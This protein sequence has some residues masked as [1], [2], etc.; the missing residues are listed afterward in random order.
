VPHGDWHSLRTS[1][2]CLP[3]A[4]QRYGF[5]DR[6][7]SFF[8]RPAD[9]FET[10]D[11]SIDLRE[12]LDALERLEDADPAES[13]PW[14]WVTSHVFRK[15]RLDSTRLDE[16]AMSPREIADILGHAKPS[17]TMDVYMGRKVVSATVA[18]VLDRA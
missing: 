14:S 13:G 4:G 12:V 16:A 3:V 2:R 11:T 8:A 5:K 15:T 18:L 17:M 10:S 7:A 9:I 1:P 6:T